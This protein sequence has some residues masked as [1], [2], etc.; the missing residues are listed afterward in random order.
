MN[1]HIGVFDSGVGG[2]TV[3][4]QLLESYPHESI[5]YFGDTARIPY[6][7]KSPETIIRY[8]IENAKL[9]LKKNIKMLV[10]ACNT[11]SAYALKPLKS[12][13]IPVVGVIEPGAKKAVEVTRNGRIAVLGTRGTIQSGEY[14]KTIHRL[15]PSVMIQ[16]IACPLFVP[17]VE[18][19]FFNHPAT[20]L[21]VQEYLA[22]IKKEK[23]DTV[24]LGCTHYPFLRAILEEEMGPHV[25]IV[26]SASTCADEVGMILKQNQIEAS[27]DCIGSHQYF[28]SDD[29]EKFKRLSL[30][31]LGQTLSV[32]L[33]MPLS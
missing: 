25:T 33:E 9:L 26:D 14:Q 17:L 30:N 7:D 27:K 15:L 16:A 3:V 13:D 20:R 2:L 32:S 8:S 18:E 21:I 6:G 22:P 31:L 19:H 5:V 28:V 1:R 10:V 12:F 24:L 29:P 11:A 4:K 23:V